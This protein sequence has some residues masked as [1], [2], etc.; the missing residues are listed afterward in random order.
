MSHSRWRRVVGW[1]LAIVIVLSTV[2]AACLVLLPRH[3]EYRV[4]NGEL[5]VITGLA[6]APRARRWPLDAIAGSREVMLRGGRRVM[7]T[8]MPGYCVGRFSY[9]G[10]GSVWQATNCRRR[11]VLLRI[12]G[13]P[14]PV[15]LSPPDPGLFQGAISGK[16]RY[17]HVFHFSGPPPPWWPMVQGFML[18]TVAIAAWVAVLLVLGPERLRYV[19]RPDALV[20]RTV[21]STRRFALAGLRARFEPSLR[22]WLRL[23][24][25]VLPSYLT[26]LF[27]ISGKTSRVYATRS[28]GPCVVLEGG[29][30]PLVLTP[31][32]PEAFLDA[33]RNLGVPVESV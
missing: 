22:I 26:G 24:G 28:K 5:V 8:A 13:E 25:I 10:I 14:R 32:E 4:E 1:F 17:A 3:L 23:W 21:F 12:E 20:V 15:L 33:L 30:W 18:L 16:T 27:R 6:L 29:R 2:L 11:A 9:R 7:G 31:A 19:L